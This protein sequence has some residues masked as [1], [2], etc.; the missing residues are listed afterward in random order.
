MLIENKKVVAVQ[1]NLTVK[2]ELQEEVLVEETEKENPFVFLFGAGNVLEA[3]EE[4]LKG[5]KVGDTFDFYIVSDEGYGKHDT[6]QVIDIPIDA[7][8]SED[9]TID[10]E[11]VR[12]G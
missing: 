6:E 9:G 10:L 1:Y 12:V 2:N 8:K 4:N 7:F 3:F 5:K 11:I